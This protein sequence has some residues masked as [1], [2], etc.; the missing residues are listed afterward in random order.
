M[1]YLVELESLDDNQK[2][3]ADTNGDGVIS[4]TDA[5]QVQKYL[6]QMITS[7]K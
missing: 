7:F 6:A 3:V 5:T 2:L 4:I 1:K